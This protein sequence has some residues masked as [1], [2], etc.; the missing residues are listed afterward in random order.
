MIMRQ[1]KA[2]EWRWDREVKHRRK[3]TVG[4]NV[5]QIK[6]TKCIFIVNKWGYLTS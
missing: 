2:K 5:L 4:I 1:W 3:E 6:E